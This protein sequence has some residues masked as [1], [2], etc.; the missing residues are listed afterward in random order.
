MT[1]FRRLPWVKEITGLAGSTIYAL[2]AKSEFPR[3]VPIGD[4]AVAWIESDV[5]NWVEERISQAQTQALMTSA[6]AAKEI[7]AEPEELDAF[8]ECGELPVVL[9]G[10]N[11]M[12]RRSALQD[13][14]NRR[15]DRFHASMA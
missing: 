11:K 1:K 8:I 15:A 3:P 6:Q 9:I 2:M 5:L 12:I 4:R 10:E 7:N 13:F 14:M